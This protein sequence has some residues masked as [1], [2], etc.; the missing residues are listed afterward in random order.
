MRASS[1][2]CSGRRLCVAAVEPAEEVEL[3]A[4]A[5][6]AHA[7]R[8]GEVRD[9]L[10]AAAE[11]GPLVDGRHEAGAPV[12]RAAGDGRPHD[13]LEHHVGRHVLILGADAVADPA[14]QRGAAGEDRAGVHLADAADVVQAVRPAR[15]DHR[16]V[17]GALGG[18]GEPVG[19]PEAPLPVLL[20]LAPGGQQRG[21]ALSHRRDDGLEGRRQGLAGQLVEL[22]LGVERVDVARPPL[23]E[24]E[25]DAL[26]PARSAP[27]G[28]R[29]RGRGTRRVEAEQVR[30]AEGA[31]AGAAIQEHLP[32]REHRHPVGNPRPSVACLVA[33]EGAS[34]FRSCRDVDRARFTL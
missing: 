32:P 13:V 5:V 23:H 7:G 34:R 2:V 9:R 22:R 11:A 12:A 4:L 24:Q 25:D 10:G 14:P 1:S 31:E 15:A 17:V 20:P 26:G 18:V 6:L 3:A 21:V 19:D 30:Q 16:Q 8:V 29:R 33:H 27:G 28:R